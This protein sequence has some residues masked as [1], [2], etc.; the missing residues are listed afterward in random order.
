MV[1]SGR[2]IIIAGILLFVAIGHNSSAQPKEQ[3]IFAINEKLVEIS[4]LVMPAVVN[5]SA[6]RNVNLKSAGEIEIPFHQ[7]D[8][9]LPSPKN[10][11]ERVSRGSGVIYN[12]R[13]YIVTNNHVI[14]NASHIKAMLADKREYRCSVVGADPATDIAV[15]K[16]D[17]VP[18]N[19]PTIK[20]GNSDV[21]RV[22]ELVMA[23][24]NPFGFSHTVT[25]GIVSAT[26][27]QNIGLAEYEEYIQTDAAIN[28]G[29]SGGA[30]VNV[31]G[32][33]VG[34]N[35]AIYSRSGGS[36]G[37]GFAIPS[38]MVQ[39]VVEELIK[40]GK[41]IRGWLGVYIQ[42]VTREIA[43]SF[44]YEKDTGVIVS[45]IMKGSPAENSDIK[46]GD[47]IVKIDGRDISDVHHLR[48]LI[49]W[50]KPGSTVKASIFREGKHLEIALPVGTMPEPKK[51]FFPILDR[52]D[53]IGI[54]VKNLTEELAYQWR[55]KEQ[56]GVVVMRLK[57]VSYTHL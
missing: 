15:I 4:K 1:S 38:N 5:I 20:M 22:G 31:K 36:L 28:P 11:Q 56:S 12:E 30:L 3:S 24:G 48:K 53:D 6:Q 18:K 33:L 42:D 29:N 23:I 7:F 39:Q 50:K 47:I 52:F 27:R 21:L 45:D 49:A 40:N 41:V 57:A 32:E 2:I 8:G 17:E 10:R 14:K 43:K 46:S 35:T 26:G 25:M 9:K 54:T 44:N 13:G 37:I 19:L 55:I 34:I 16:I 51:E